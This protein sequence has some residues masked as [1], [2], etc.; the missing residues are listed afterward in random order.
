VNFI[1]NVAV[2]VLHEDQ[3]RR[4]WQR[5]HDFC[6]DTDGDGVPDPAEG[7]FVDVDGDSLP[8]DKEQSIKPAGFPLDPTNKYSCRDVRGWYVANLDDEHCI[9]YG[10]E[11][12]WPIDSIDEL[13][14]A[15]PG[16]QWP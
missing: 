13:D 15:H 11:L 4:N 14:W 7:C 6:A 10:A 3:H 2:T 16:S 12:S 8:D 1:D 5:W 9:A